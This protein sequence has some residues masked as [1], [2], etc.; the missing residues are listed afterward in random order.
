MLKSTFARL[1]TLRGQLILTA[2]FCCLLVPANGC[3]KSAVSNQNAGSSS[4][5]NSDGSAVAGGGDKSIACTLLTDD[6][7]KTAQ[8]SALKIRNPTVVARHG[9]KTSQCLYQTEDINRGVSVSITEP[10]PDDPQKYSVATLWKKMFTRKS[11][12][13]AEREKEKEAKAAPRDRE[14]EDE[15]EKE[16]E[17]GTQKRITGLGSD[18][19]WVTSKFGG[20]LYVLIN[21]RML[22]VSVG[23][24]D[25][26]ETK[27]RNA[28]AL[29]RAAMSRM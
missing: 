11:K 15:E 24:P 14:E 9:Y 25:N 4:A 17:S 22:R 2:V 3:H 18:A 1:Q 13:E 16:A 8:A 7:I 20:V 10:D 28:T 27:F 21:D 12:V 23:G 26:L 5:G 6:E 29:A 19:Y